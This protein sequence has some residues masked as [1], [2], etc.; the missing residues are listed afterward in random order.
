MV[1]AAALVGD[2]GSAGDFAERYAFSLILLS[3]T[4]FGVAQVARLNFLGMFMVT[5]GAS[6]LSPAM[7][8]LK[9]PNE[10]YHHS[11]YALLATILLL[12]AWPLIKW[13]T[14]PAETQA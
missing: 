14:A 6:L 11:G 2:W 7:A 1:A 3:V 5:S 12:L 4:V 13:W 10:A 9:Q 8:L